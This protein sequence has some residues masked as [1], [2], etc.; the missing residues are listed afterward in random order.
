[1][2]TQGDHMERSK[3]EVPVSRPNWPLGWARI[4]RQA[5]E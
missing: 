2:E 4:N 3:Q 5:Y 1:M